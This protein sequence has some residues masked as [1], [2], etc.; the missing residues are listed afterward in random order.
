MIKRDKRLEVLF[1][2]GCQNFKTLLSV[3]SEE[4]ITA[5][6]LIDIEKLPENHPLRSFSSPTLL[7]NG[8]AIL[9]AKTSNQGLSCSVITK[10]E[11]IAEI[12][13]SI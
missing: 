11:M 5:Y 6:E 7:L 3:L 2:P 10:S 12:R 13:R 4:G 1:F 9:G 8:K